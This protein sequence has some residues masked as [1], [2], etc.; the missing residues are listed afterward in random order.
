MTAFRMM[1]SL[2][3]A[4]LAVA[5][6]L[7]GGQASERSGAA[8]A[9]APSYQAQWQDR[10]TVAITR[11]VSAEQLRRCVDYKYKRNRDKPHELLVRCTSDGRAWQ[12]Y[13]VYTDSYTALGPYEPAP[14]YD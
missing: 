3:A 6:V 11:A 13:L 2:A 14:A 7:A 9:M 8:G 5:P 12:T 1:A 10:P 4:W